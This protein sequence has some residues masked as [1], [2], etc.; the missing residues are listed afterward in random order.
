MNEEG[1]AR[2]GRLVRAACTDDTVF[3]RL[4]Y[5][6]LGCDFPRCFLSLLP[7]KG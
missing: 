4:D 6:C 5:M 7:S 1:S 2:F 3:W